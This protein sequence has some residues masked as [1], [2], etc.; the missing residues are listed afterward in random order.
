MKETISLDQLLN[1][2]NV[3][4]PAVESVSTPPGVEPTESV[5]P[6]K[7]RTRVWLKYAATA[8]CGIIA[9]LFVVWLFSKSGPIGRKRPLSFDDMEQKIV[10]AESVGEPFDFTWD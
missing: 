10:P 3:A 2:G 6:E 5:I 7:R 8:L 1:T 9:T 4:V